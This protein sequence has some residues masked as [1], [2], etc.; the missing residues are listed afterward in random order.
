MAIVTSPSNSQTS[1]NKLTN[2]RLTNKVNAC[3]KIPLY[4]NF[5]KSIPLV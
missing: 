3:N 2:L 4:Y 5:L 1:D